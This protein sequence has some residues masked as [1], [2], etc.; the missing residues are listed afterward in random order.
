LKLVPLKLV[1][2]DFALA[3]SSSQK[4]DA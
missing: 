3:L 1:H 2:L 4:D